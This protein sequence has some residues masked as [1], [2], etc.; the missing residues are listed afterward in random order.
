M[1][2]LKSIT[3]AAWLPARARTAESRFAD[4]SNILPMSNPR[5]VNKEHNDMVNTIRKF[6]GNL[7]ELINNEVW[8]EKEVER[9]TKWRL[10]NIFPSKKPENQGK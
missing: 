10:E 2:R 1:T 4:A 9:K 3:A 6:R 8:D 5:A 7:E